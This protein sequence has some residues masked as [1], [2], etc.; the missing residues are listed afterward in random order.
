MHLSERI[1]VTPA[2][3]GKTRAATLDPQSRRG[4]PGVASSGS[5]GSWAQSTE[6]ARVAVK[7]V[8]VLSRA[9]FSCSEVY[10]LVYVVSFC[11][12]VV[13]AYPVPGT[14]C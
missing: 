7:R 9:L 8:G 4:A 2:D 5:T 1:R 13:R 10:T 12:R 6:H 11:V 3:L 14:L